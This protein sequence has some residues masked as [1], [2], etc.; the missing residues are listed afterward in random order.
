MTTREDYVTLSQV[1]VDLNIDA[2]LDSRS[3]VV[4]PALNAA[5]DA[6]DRYCRRQ[7]DVTASQRRSFTLRRTRSWFRAGDMAYPPLMV[8]IR[9]KYDDD[10]WT[11]LETN[12]WVARPPQSD[13]PD[14]PMRTLDRIDDDWPQAVF[15]TV[16]VTGQWG[17][18]NVPSVVTQA[19]R[20][21]AVRYVARFKN[22]IL[23]AA[24]H[25]SGMDELLRYDP[26]VKSL[27]ACV[28]LSKVN[29]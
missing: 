23:A 25:P 8:E 11:T 7:F 12:K 15:S 16:R 28:R 26:D 9:D 1:H 24:S 18:A 3:A 4:E 21:L 14:W 22:T 17:W 2:D 6:V 5:H 27:L 29:G 20:L 10:A 13:Q 19:T